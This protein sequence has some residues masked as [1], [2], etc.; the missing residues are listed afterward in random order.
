MLTR[1]IRRQLVLFAILTV[2]AL[3]VLG[4]YY[5]RLPTLAGIG[6][7][8]LKADLPASGGL[9]PTANVTY[10]GITIGKVTDVEP[11]EHGAQAT[12]SID[13]RYKI[14]ADASANVHSVSAV[15]EQYLDLVSSGAPG[16]FFSPGQTITNGTVPSEIG[17]A[18]D[19][20]NRGLE[21]LPKDKIGQLLDETAEAV[22]GLGPALQR[23]VDST[24]AIV[25]DFKTNINDVDD[26]IQNSAPILDSQATSRSAID[27]WAHN[28]NILGAESAQEDSHL[29]SILSQ[30]AP[31]ADQVN[32]VFSDV[33]DSLPQT[34]ANLEI[35][36]EMLKRYHPG[37]EQTLVFL[38]QL[39]S[40]VQS[41]SAPYEKDHMA[42]LDLSLAINYPPPCL[43]G[44]K[45]AP[46]WRA[47]V[48]T[49]IA[50]LSSG[51]Y[52]RIPQDFQANAVRGARNMPCM[53]VPGKRAPTPQACRSNKPYV[54]LGTNPWFGDPN[55]IRNC[56][57]P[58]ARCDQPVDPGHVIPA[59]SVNNGLN[60]LPA[61]RLPPGGLTPPPI[62]DPLQRPGTGSVQ[63][64]G[65][66]P[67]PCIYTPGGPPAAVY[68]P[69]SGEVVGPDGSK[70]SVNNSSNTGDD[71]WKAMLAPAG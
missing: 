55:Q 29:K 70:Y 9:Y 50:P 45:P 23:L 11:T 39:G 5:L 68:S 4:W 69:M 6:Q 42:A 37:V 33:R 1:F 10:R 43:T 63:C 8:Q 22:G 2:V 71:G 34:L 46:E 54:P 66:Q 62:S 31:T 36:I 16:R 27:R 14:P 49:S 52:C 3:L 17:P 44:F 51:Q 15:G 67:N 58:G 57:A 28:L 59:P 21:V 56:P 25:G 41:I 24:Q 48:D 40:I 32:S 20:A 26:I 53:D 12:M 30:A 38:P 19:T 61:D 65:Q 13:N 47:P 18:L 35:V 64:N 7:Y 60:P